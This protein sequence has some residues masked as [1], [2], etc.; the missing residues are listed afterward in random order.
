MCQRTGYGH[1]LPYRGTRTRPETHKQAQSGFQASAARN[2][3]APTGKFCMGLWS[4]L[5]CSIV[6]LANSVGCE[7]VRRPTGQSRVMYEGRT[8]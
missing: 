1:S 7:C 3:A 6:H 2:V 8:I 4:P 5:P